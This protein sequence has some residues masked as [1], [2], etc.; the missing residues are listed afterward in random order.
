MGLIL[1]ILLM[2]TIGI[3][4]MINPAN[5]GIGLTCV[6]ESML[7]VVIMWS[8]TYSVNELQEVRSC[9]DKEIIRHAWLQTKTNFIN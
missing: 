3:S 1:A 9:V 4:F 6:V 5:F 8:N 7:F 2:W